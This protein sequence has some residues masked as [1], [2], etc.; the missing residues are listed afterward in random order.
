MTVKPRKVNEAVVS[1]W[2][3]FRYLVIGAY[4]GFATIVG[5][6]W[7]FVYSENGPRLPYSELV[8]WEFENLCLFC[9]AT[10]WISLELQHHELMLVLP[11]TIQNK[12]LCFKMIFL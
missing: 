10:F 3:F 9:V 1:G 12:R 2:L 7:W 4:V 8:S 5:F 11:S 6:V